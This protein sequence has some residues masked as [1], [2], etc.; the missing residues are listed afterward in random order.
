MGT[1]SQEILSSTGIEKDFLWLVYNKIMELDENITCEITDS[2]GTVLGTDPDSMAW[3]NDDF[4][5]IDFSLSETV[6]L[7]L[8]TYT[9]WGGTNGYN[10]GLYCG[11][12][13]ILD[14]GL[15]SRTWNGSAVNG[16]YLGPCIRFHEG[17]EKLASY[18]VNL[19]PTT[20][21]TRSWLFSKYVNDT[22]GMTIIWFGDYTKSSFT[23]ANVCI[24]KF[25]VTEGGVEKT[26]W[27]AYAGLSAI[28]N[29]ENYD[30]D[31]NNPTSKSPMFSFEA[32]TGYLDFISHS[33][34]VSGS[35]KAFTS[36][37]IYDCTTVNF[38]DTLSLKDGANF[39]AI[40]AHSMVR[41]DEEEG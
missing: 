13:K 18:Y 15:G 36:T 23:G 8:Q 24:M 1:W 28:E 12:N 20:E 34:F 27:A 32:R 5:N 29:S 35:T 7:R 11:S 22:T 39:L 17:R 33:S 40:G 38:G 21:A 30:S 3:V 10:F 37:D 2:S 9:K 19:Y 16:H 26:K 4:T 6:K 31:G 25:K 14:I 41:L